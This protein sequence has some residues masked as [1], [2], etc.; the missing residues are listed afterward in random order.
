MVLI[1][2]NFL[3]YFLLLF[4]VV[5]GSF[6]YFEWKQM[7]C[8][9]MDSVNASISVQTGSLRYVGLNADTD[10]FKFGKVSPGSIVRR[11]I[12]VEYDR[13][14]MVTVLVN[15]TFAS[16]VS[17]NPAEF[18][19]P[20]DQRREVNFDV[21]IPETAVDGNYTATVYFCFRNVGD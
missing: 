7:Q 19:L 18:Y 20:E 10:S 15:G 16:W 4:I 1:R 5:M 6:I 13:E 9:T 2:K 3:F 21:T 17:V 14:V 11:S 8:S 12:K